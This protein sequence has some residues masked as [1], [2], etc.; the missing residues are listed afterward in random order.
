[1]ANQNT[2]IFCE[3]LQDISQNTNRNYVLPVAR[4]WMLGFARDNKFCIGNKWREHGQ[5]E[6]KELHRF[7]IESELRIINL[8]F[9]HKDVI[10]SHGVLEIADQ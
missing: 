8:F 1:M 2:Q 3:T 5:A 10:N 9:R 6:W 7:S 4:V